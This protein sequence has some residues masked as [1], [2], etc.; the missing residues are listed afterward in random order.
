MNIAM[1]KAMTTTKAAQP[2]VKQSKAVDTATPDANAFGSVFKTVSTRN[3][4]QVNS[5][6]TTSKEALSEE[7]TAILSNDSL[8]SLLDEL[9]V[10]MD[11]AGLF[12]MVGEEATPVPMDEMLTLENLTELLGMTEEQL[13]QMV[14]QFVGETEQEITDVWSIIEQAPAILSEILSYLQGNQQN[15]VGNAN[16]SDDVK[17]V[18]QF[19][20]LAELFG[21]K[22]DTVYQQE[23]QLTQLKDALSTLASQVQ[24][25]NVNTQQEVPKAFQQIVQQIT[26]QTSAKTETETQSQPIVSVQ[27]TTQTKTV[28]ITLPAEKPAQS[29]A[30]MKEIQNLISRSQLSGQQG[31]MKLLLKLFPENLGQIRIELVQKDGVLT[32]RLLATTSHGKELLETNINQLKAGFVSQN[33]QMERIDIAQSLQ[34]A[35]RNTR[36]QNF[37]NNFF[38]QQDQDEVEENDDDQEDEKV[39]FKA[40]LDEEVK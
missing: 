35:D 24:V 26:Q 32:A 9:G 34:D 20:K 37:F 27:Q 7:V 33:I 38:R 22:M 14:Q 13:T 10:E 1:L 18:I 21:N 6:N 40:L 11:E 36:D 2:N 19:L 25:V 12:V 30:L 4:Q 8:E 23:A 28:T 17:Q 39:S 5:T 15:Q 31:N 3:Q 16:E 29:E